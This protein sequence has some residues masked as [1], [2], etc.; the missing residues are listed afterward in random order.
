MM[1]DTFCFLSII[2]AKL[3][4]SSEY[5]HKKMRKLQKRWN[6]YE[7]SALFHKKCVT[8]HPD[9]KLK[10]TT[11]IILNGTVTEEIRELP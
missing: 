10:E 4:I 5:W 11:P 9:S 6:Y 7:K 3:H 2:G 1:N 8:L